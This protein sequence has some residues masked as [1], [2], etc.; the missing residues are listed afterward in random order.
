M[1][2]VYGPWTM[3]TGV[4]NDTRVHGPW[5]RPV[6]TGVKK[7]QPCPWPLDTGIILDTCIHGPWT[8][9]V[10]TEIWLCDR[11][12]ILSVNNLC[13]LSLSVLILNWSW[14]RANGELAYPDSPAEWPLKWRWWQLWCVF[15]LNCQLQ[16]DRCH[17]VMMPNLKSIIIQDIVSDQ[18]INAY[19]HK[20]GTR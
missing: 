10:C 4:Q 12:G 1:G 17:M 11:K 15:C 9:I 16:I 19:P 3:N 6:N 5:P 14:N 13:H 2:S 7:W 20:K 18:S 8:Q